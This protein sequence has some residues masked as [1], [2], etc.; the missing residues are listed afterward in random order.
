MTKKVITLILLAL[1]GALM[2]SS[3]TSSSLAAATSWPG[4]TADVENEVVYLS[5]GAYVYAVSSKSG[6]EIWHYPEDPIRGVTFYAPATIA[7]DLIVAG[8]YKTSLHAIN[9]NTG[10]EAWVF[11]EARDKYVGASTFANDMVFA[12]SADYNIYAL[13]LNNGDL[14]FTVETEKSNWASAVSDG[15]TVYVPSMDH[16]IY[17]FDANSGDIT[18][19]TDV[20]GAIAAAPILVDDVLYITTLN[21]ET[22]ALDC[23]D[24]NILWRTDMEDFAWA[25]PAMIEDT[26]I[27][28]N[29]SGTVF[30]LDSA[31]GSPLW[32]ADSGGEVTAA[33]VAVEGGFV[34][35]THDA[36]VVSFSLDGG[37]QWTRSINSDTGSLP[38]TPV[39][40]GELIIIPVAQSSENLIVA[41]DMNGN[42][43]WDF[44]PEK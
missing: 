9:A 42:E 17:A 28:I 13:D 36:E 34:V 39:V 24:G 23:T 16:S 8:D 21:E 29:A 5:A 3:C 11:S 18:W 37:K 19:K 10:N 35:V 4:I 22:V 30:A 44:A 38:S 41:F 14:N 7:G 15:E 33:A 20:D 26:L 32:S 2:I 31:D 12:P 40:V 27:V 43:I 6:S 1:L 25:P